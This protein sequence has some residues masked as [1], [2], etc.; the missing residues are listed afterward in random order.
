[1]EEKPTEPAINE[2]KSDSDRTLL[3]AAGVIILMVA[4]IVAIRYIFPEKPKT[5][6]Q[7]IDDTLN[8]HDTENNFLYNNFA[9]VKVGNTWVTR[10]Q[11]GDKLYTVPLRFNPKQLEDVQIVGELDKRFVP[12]NLYITFDP[13]GDVFTYVALAAG[14]LSINLAQALDVLPTAACAYN[15]TEAC[16]DRPIVSCQDNDKAVIF[17]REANETMVILQGNCMVLQGE[18][19]NLLKAVDRVLYIWYGIM[20][21]SSAQ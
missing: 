12:S 17:L 1:M 15:V 6:D 8:G 3:I 18:E 20:P 9:F 2:K 5:I 19:M 11:K 16:Y 14:E 10:V 13:R 21:R 4:A 7:I